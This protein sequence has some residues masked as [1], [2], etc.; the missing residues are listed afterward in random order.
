[1]I[2]KVMNWANF[3]DICN[4]Y[5]LKMKITDSYINVNQIIIF[6]VS[7]NINNSFGGELW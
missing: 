7:L 1:M 3:L 4:S 2:T 5:P 6:S